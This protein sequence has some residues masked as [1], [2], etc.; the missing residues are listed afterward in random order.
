RSRRPGG[1]KQP[2]RG[3]ER[4][5]ILR[6]RRQH[7]CDE[8]VKWVFLLLVRDFLDRWQLQTVDRARESAHHGGDVRR[9]R[10]LP[11]GTGVSGGW[12]ARTAATLSAGRPALARRVS[13]VPPP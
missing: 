7:G 1:A 13:S 10:C 4:R 3:G 5:R 12:P 2:R 9:R 6:P 11:H 8:D